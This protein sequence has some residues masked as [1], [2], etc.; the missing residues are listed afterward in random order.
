MLRIELSIGLQGERKKR[1]FHE[2]L[3][4]ELDGINIVENFYDILEAVVR[5]AET[6]FQGEFKNLKK[7]AVLEFMTPYTR[8][9][10]QLEKMLESTVHRL[11]NK[12]IYKRL[13]KT[14]RKLF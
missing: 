2:H 1:T 4:R 8:D 5:A 11:Y 14:F 6:A 9:S 10:K 13:W 12:S 3:Q 7:E